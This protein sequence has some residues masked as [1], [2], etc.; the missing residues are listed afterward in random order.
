MNTMEVCPAPVGGDSPLL[1]LKNNAQLLGSK[2]QWFFSFCGN[3]GMPAR[4][5]CCHVG[6]AARGVEPLKGVVDAMGAG[7]CCAPVLCLAKPRA[8]VCG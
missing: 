7:L 8:A 6:L 5:Q 4:C 1:G 2:Q 3:A